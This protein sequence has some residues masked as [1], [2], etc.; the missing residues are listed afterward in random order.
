MGTIILIA[1]I[2][3]FSMI[4]LLYCYKRVVNRSLEQS[5]NEKIQQQTIFSL[6]QYEIFK[7]DNG[8]RTFEL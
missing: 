7:D 3:S 4:V 8:R 2:I 5:L 6:G 1:V